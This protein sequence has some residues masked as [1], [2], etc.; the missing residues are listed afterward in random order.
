MANDD[1]AISH[2][3]ALIERY[4]RGRS[5]KQIERENNLPEGA[6]SRTLRP[7]QRGKF[8]RYETQK[9]FADALSAPLDEVSEAFGRDSDSS[10]LGTGGLT[11]YER[12]LLA[13]T[14]RLNHD[15]RAMLLTLARLTAQQNTATDEIET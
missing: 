5:I 7:S 4:A 11:T 2:V 14:R 3:D 13:E 6:L 15:Q 9:R 12:D 10:Y 1:P 8:P